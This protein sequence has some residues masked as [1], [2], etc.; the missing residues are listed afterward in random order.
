MPSTRDICGS[1]EEPL[2]PDMGRCQPYRLKKT[3]EVAPLPVIQC[4][5]DEYTTAFDNVTQ[6]FYVTARLFDQDCDLIT[7]ENGDA[8]TLV[9]S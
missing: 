3:C 2:N 4:A 8:I 7:D 6:K 1:F 5:D 9:L